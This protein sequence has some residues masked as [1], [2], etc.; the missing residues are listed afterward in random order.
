MLWGQNKS[1]LCTTSSVSV[2]G[3][4]YVGMGPCLYNKA[5]VCVYFYY[6]CGEPTFAIY[7]ILLI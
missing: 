2:F 4:D 5:I 1:I 6:Y 7:G 3:V